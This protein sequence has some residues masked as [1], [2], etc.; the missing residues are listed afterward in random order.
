MHPD[1]PQT[2][3]PA[4]TASAPTIVARPSYY[5]RDYRPKRVALSLML[6]VFGVLFAYDG[7][8]GWPRQ[9]ERIAQLGRDIENARRENREE[10]VR[11]ADAER[12]KIKLHSGMD[13]LMQKVLAFALIPGGLAL[14]VWSLYQSRGQYRLA[15]NVL[16]VPGH[17]PVPL[18]AITTIDKTQWKRKGI[19][20]LDYQL[21]GGEK[22][23]V[24]LDD[25]VYQQ[26]PTDD[27]FAH[28]ERYTGTADE[29]TDGGPAT[30]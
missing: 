23:R 3:P 13:I 28:I 12:S 1:V 7:F 14:L 4:D 5:W 25:I 2:Q 22:G 11:K 27:I 21:P 24:T 18:D 6:V 15:E 26:Y 16:H 20:Y 17:P 29:S 19:A 9:N 10:D 8:V 30:A